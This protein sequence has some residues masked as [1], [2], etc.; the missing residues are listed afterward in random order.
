MG[1][2]WGGQGLV[3][4]WAVD[5]SV[6]PAPPPWAAKIHGVP[7]GNMFGKSNQLAKGCWLLEPSEISVAGPNTSAK[8]AGNREVVL[9]VPVSV[10]VSVALSKAAIEATGR[11]KPYHTPEDQIN[12]T[13][14]E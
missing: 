2:A 7:L 12:C 13:H 10:S 1:L 14:V 9:S 5:T 6:L 3:G 11:G 4:L 8:L